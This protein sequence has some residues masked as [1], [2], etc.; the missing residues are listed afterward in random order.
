MAP[1]SAPA[2][3]GEAASLESV[4]A[5]DR[6]RPTVRGN[7]AHSDSGLG[8]RGQAGSAAPRRGRRR[9]VRVGSASRGTGNRLGSSSPA[10]SDRAGDSGSSRVSGSRR[11]GLRGST[12]AAGREVSMIDRVEGPTRRGRVASVGSRNSRVEVGGRAAG[13]R[14]R[15]LE[16]ACREAAAFVR[17][18]L[19][20][21][22]ILRR[23]SGR[24]AP[25]PDS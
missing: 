11:I 5:A 20:V 19:P 3:D 4:G 1:G 14:D 22:A 17:S 25:G 16:E 18:S 7:P 24:R 21:P 2:D 15:A 6:P 13:N 10:T 23:A 8:P 9:R 12:G